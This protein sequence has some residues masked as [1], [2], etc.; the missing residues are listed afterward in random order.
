MHVLII[1]PDEV[2]AASVAE[3]IRAD[4]PGQEMM[5]RIWPRLELRMLRDFDPEMVIIACE[6]PDR[7]MLEA[8]QVAN[9]Q[10]PRPVVMFVDRSDANATAQ[11]LEAGVAAYIVDGYNPK[12]M[13]S[14]LTVAAQRF[15]MTQSL[16]ND[17]NK[18]KADLAARK[19]IDRAKGVLMKSRNLTEDEAYKVLRKHAM[20]TGR[21]I[22]AVAADILAVSDLLKP[23]GE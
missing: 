4:H 19:T 3:G 7:D 16:R 17:L 13:S 21:P 15:A 2:R 18:A 10:V 9:E 1:D 5:V 6:S 23:G 20:D 22:Q 11:A 14:I 8:L 12:R